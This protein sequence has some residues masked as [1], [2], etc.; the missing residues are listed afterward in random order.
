MT[1][2]HG[3]F[4]LSISLVETFHSDISCLCRCECPSE[5][6]TTLLTLLLSPN[7]LCVYIH[8]KH[9]IP[10]FFAHLVCLPCLLSCF[11]WLGEFSAVTHTKLYTNKQR[12][13]HLHIKCSW[14][15][16][17]CGIFLSLLIGFYYGSFLLV[18]WIHTH[19]RTLP[20]SLKGLHC[21]NGN[22]DIY[23]R[24]LCVSAVYKLST[25]LKLSFFACLALLLL[26]PVIYSASCNTTKSSIQTIFA[27]FS[28]L[29]SP[30]FLFLSLGSLWEAFTLN[31]VLQKFCAARC[32][33][34]LLMR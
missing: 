9:D 8:I 33:Y 22:L 3:G 24:V 17:F 23:V 14:C 34:L 7:F 18:M 15:V 16:F 1:R 27:H 10:S 32:Y 6:Q 30:I 12:Y 26:F 19:E 4:L 5:A 13:T 28:P 29:F 2:L 31:G 25:L 21:I 20:F 11:P